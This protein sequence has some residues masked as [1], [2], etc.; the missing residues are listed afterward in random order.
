MENK[1]ER[2]IDWVERL[3]PN[4]YENM[5]Y[6]CREVDCEC[7]V[8]ESKSCECHFKFPPMKS[9]KE[10]GIFSHI[11][12]PFSEDQTVPDEILKYIWGSHYDEGGNIRLEHIENIK[13]SLNQSWLS[14][15]CKF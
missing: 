4:H 9:F 11:I 14:Y 3:G 7:H 10:G 1:E 13:K 2:E 6:S 12:L 8:C 15:T 5:C